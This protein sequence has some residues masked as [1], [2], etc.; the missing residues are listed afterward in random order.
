M[1]LR[2]AK[3]EDF[4]RIKEILEESEFRLEFEHLQSL[5]IVEEKKKIVAV[6]SLQTILEAMFVVDNS[7]TKR[8]KAAALSLLLKKSVEEVSKLGYENFHAFAMNES[9]K[10]ILIRRKAVKVKG[11]VLIRWI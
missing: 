9:I 4:N 3:R 5:F 6:G 8:N 11:E 10:K 2:L 7:A 1:I